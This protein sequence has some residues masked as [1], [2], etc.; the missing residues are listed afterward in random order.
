MIE[1]WGK[2]IFQKTPF[3]KKHYL[4]IEQTL[5]AIQVA[6]AFFV[7]SILPICVGFLLILV[8][9]R[10][11]NRRTK[12]AI[13]FRRLVLFVVPVFVT[14]AKKAHIVVG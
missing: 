10:L 7:A 8:F 2:G 13:T 9:V 5:N 11:K 3:L 12:D 4:L 6:F 14:L 1:M